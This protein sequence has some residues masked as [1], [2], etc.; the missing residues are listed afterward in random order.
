MSRNAATCGFATSFAISSPA[1]AYGWDYAVRAR[2]AK[3]L[4]G[5]LGSA[6]R[7]TISMSGR[8]ALADSVT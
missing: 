8:A 5:V 7:A 6:A 2:E 3:L 4:G 1:V